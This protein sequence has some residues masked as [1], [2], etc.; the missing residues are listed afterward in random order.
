MEYSILKD[1]AEWRPQPFWS[2]NDKLSPRELLRQI[3]EMHRAGYGGFFMHSR[4]GLVTRYLSDEWFSLVRICAEYAHSLG[5]K[6]WLYDEDMWPSGYASG[7]VVRLHPEFRHCALLSIP[8]DE[9]RP[10]DKVV[11]PGKNRAIVIRY[12]PAQIDRFNHS[13]YIDTMNPLAVRC[14]LDCT[15]ER[16]A[17]AV[18]D[19]FGEAIEGIFTD[20][21]SYT[22]FFYGRPFVPYS[23]Y[24]R[25]RIRKKFGYDILTFARSL[26]EESEEAPRIRREYYACANEQFLE[27]YMGQY[28]AWCDAHGLKFTGHFGC[29]DTM[30]EQVMVQGSVMAGYPYFTMPG[31]DKLQRPLEQL[32]TVRQLTSAARQLGDQRSLCECFAGIGHE[33]GFRKRKQIADW[34]CLNGINFL[35]P[36]LTPYSL[37]GERK[38][39]YPPALGWQQPWWGEEEIFSAYLER[40]C[41]LA[42]LPEVGPR[43]LLIQPL[44]TVASL[45]SPETDLTAIRE[46]DRRFRELSE[47]LLRAQAA[48]D[49]G[50][51]SL[52]AEYGKVENGQLVIGKQSYSAVVLCDCR[53]LRETT[54]SLLVDL[55]RPP[56]LL[57][58]TPEGLSGESVDTPSLILEF[59][60]RVVSFSEERSIHRPEPAEP[61]RSRVLIR[62]GER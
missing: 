36:H 33:S 18:G 12:A 7:E 50:D 26:F 1:S 19:L 57:G 35:N 4:V 27:S 58:R 62:E 25:D 55:S 47:G 5:M 59:S 45:Y 24:L 16:Y 8:P 9:I 13:C 46:I 38:R 23:E 53:S 22:L 17:K 2:W 37:R 14:F 15:H 31:I 61:W 42:A 60:A 21:P 54:R 34:L 32:V 48:F 51:E 43:I 28:R 39:D 44:D 20:E 40:M 29:E 56:L 41:R 52:I 10:D 6:A 30:L 3:D 11:S 49:Y